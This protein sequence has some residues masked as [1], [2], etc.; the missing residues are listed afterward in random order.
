MGISRTK[1]VENTVRQAIDQ[2]MFVENNTRNRQL[3]VKAV[4]RSLE[5]AGIGPINIDVR[6]E[7]TC[8]N[9]YSLLRGECRVGIYV[10]TSP[11]LWDTYQLTIRNTGNITWTK[12]KQESIIEGVQVLLPYHIIP[13]SSEEDFVDYLESV[14]WKDKR[15]EHTWKS[16]VTKSIQTMWNQLSLREKII[17]FVLSNQQVNAEDW[18]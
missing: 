7:K 8:N 18:Y 1:K 3:M 14:Q 16:Y 5:N 2:F 15:G 12:I 17:T 4:R 9:I 11:N 6:E 10:E 13:G